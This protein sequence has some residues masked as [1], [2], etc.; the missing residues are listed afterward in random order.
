MCL[1]PHCIVRRVGSSNH[2]C[3][4]HGF[5]TNTARRPPGFP[6]AGA[7]RVHGHAPL[8]PRAI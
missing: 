5:I 4:N 1:M 8:A 2:N 6:A 7:W 3:L